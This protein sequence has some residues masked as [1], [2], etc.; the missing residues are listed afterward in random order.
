M[1]EPIKITFHSNIHEVLDFVDVCSSFPEDIDVFAGRYIV[2]GKSQMGVT[3]ICTL[4][5]IA[6]VIHTDNEVNAGLFADAM[7]RFQDA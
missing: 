3:A 2:D 7:K 1:R 5:D 6:T 4:P